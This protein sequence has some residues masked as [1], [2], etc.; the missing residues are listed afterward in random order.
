[1]YQTLYSTLMEGSWWKRD[2]MI[3]SWRGCIRTLISHAWKYVELLECVSSD[4]YVYQG[5]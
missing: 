2:L 1:M 4:M 3:R 5:V